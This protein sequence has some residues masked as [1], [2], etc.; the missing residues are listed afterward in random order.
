MGGVTN[1]DPDYSPARLLREAALRS[2]ER[3]SIT[4]IEVG[5]CERQYSV[6]QSQKHALQLVSLLR[7]RGV[8]TGDRVLVWGPN[9]AWHLWTYIACAHLG[10]IVVPVQEHLTSAEIQA[11]V[12]HCEPRVAIVGLAQAERGGLQNAITYAELE[13][14]IDAEPVDQAPPVPCPA[15]T[16]GAII[17]TSGTTAHP[18]GVTLTHDQLWW[19]CR[20]FRDVF[21]YSSATVHAVVAPLSH[22]GGFN[23]ATTDIFANGGH[24]VIIDHFTPRAV[25][26]ALEEHRVQMMFAVPT[27]YQALL[28]DSAWRPLPDFTRPLT[29]GAPLPSALAQQLLDRQLDVIN[30]W[31][32]TE[33][34]A[35]GTCMRAST[36]VRRGDLTG[37]GTAFPYTR[38][39]VARAVDPDS[40]TIEW[41]DPGEDGELL[42]SGPSITSG[43]WRDRELTRTTIV[44]DWLRT[45][46]WGRQDQDGFV[47]F[48]GRVVDTINTGGEKV[49]PTPIAEVISTHPAVRD[50]VVVGVPDPK[51][52]QAVGAVLVLNDGAKAPS[53]QEIRRYAGQYLARYKLPH[54]LAVTNQFPTNANGKP[55]HRALVELLTQ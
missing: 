11:L 51:W 46:D 3:T 27:M 54:Y 24:V 6:A 17:Y 32:M 20:N 21:E 1:T 14:T 45:G 23:G 55:S 47:T 42:C 50:C 53:L 52:G 30:V 35:S 22:I 18:K 26:D 10:A 4:Y 40:G 19:G 9:S 31:G 43:Y 49:L 36:A 2:P 48:L 33:Q 5:A 13:Q 7:R 38:V 29:G 37:S 12:H 41:A 44:N 15:G 34:S 39:R 28:N 25:L 8:Q 16:M